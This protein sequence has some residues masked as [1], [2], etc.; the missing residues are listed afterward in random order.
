MRITFFNG[1]SA[2]EDSLMGVEDALDHA[3]GVEGVD[4]CVNIKIADDDET[5]SLNAR[6]RGVEGTTDVLSFPAYDFEGLLAGAMDTVDPVMEDGGVFI[7]D[8]VISLPRAR[9]QAREYGHSL[10]REMAFLALHGSLHLLGYDH[11]NEQDE[12][13]M[14]ERQNSILGQAGIGRKT[15]G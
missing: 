9:E 11:E 13:E 1:E 15:D 12:Q 6:F 4:F 3:A 5:A 8:I 2:P 14:L 10:K 7:G